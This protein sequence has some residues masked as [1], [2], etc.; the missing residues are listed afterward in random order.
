MLEFPTASGAL[1][2]AEEIAA[3]SDPPVR[4]GVHLGEVSVTE[5][6]DL[7][8]H[9]VNVA[10]RIQQMASPGAVLASGDVKRAIRG[11][12]GE[13]L[14]SQ[15]SVR[16][17]KMSETLPVFA[18]APAEGGRA[19][20]RRLDL[21]SPAIAAVAAL[22]LALAGLGLWLARGV[23]SGSAPRSTRVAILPFQSLGGG[24]QF[25]DFAA[26]LR[27]QIVGVMSANDVP[28]VSQA[29]SEALRGQG[30]GEIVAR[31][32][33]T[34]LLDG[35]V[36]S[37]GRTIGVRVD[38]EDPRQHAT[39]WTASV[40]APASQ[41][42]DLQ[43]RIAAK[44][45]NVLMCAND[46][47]RA[48]SAPTDSD[49]VALFFHAC[50]LSENMEGD[51]QRR[52]QVLDALRQVTSRAPGFARGHSKLASVLADRYRFMPSDQG[53]DRFREASAEARRAL[54]IDPNDADAYQALSLL[55]PVTAFTERERLL[56]RGLSGAPS[57]AGLSFRY[58]QFLAEVGRL[59]EAESFA[60]RAAAHEPLDVQYA[61]YVPYY[62]A[63]GGGSE[64]AEEG[65]VQVSRTW[66]DS[67][68]GWGASLSVAIWAGQT[69]RALAILARAPSYAP[70]EVIEH[71]R[72]CV[73]AMKTLAPSAVA[74]ARRREEARSAGSQADLRDAIQCLAPLELVDASFAMSERYQPTLYVLEGSA[75][76][77]FPST[78][79]M[80]RDRR[81][82][83]LAARIGLVDYWR[84]T[85]KWPDFCS[86]PGLPY[87]CKT[88]AAKVASKRAG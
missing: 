74:A 7:L 65:I 26:G 52:E 82:M 21:R 53:A 61:A 22:V 71:S 63:A 6:G 12:L 34:L 73:L 31:L 85:G 58:A 87:D 13:R 28:T 55:Q 32:G 36:R 86:Q 24:A 79:P 83:K 42:S 51:L 4:T 49:T 38:L 54:A 15:G 80:R 75:I 30:R 40:E 59:G 64:G 44:I 25:N 60:Q 69:D 43:H 84:S 68:I 20:G 14:R 27:D 78:A 45:T 16:L 62:E 46:L 33:V 50:D 37:D 67:P 77:F 41:G 23:W 18:L 76:F 1:A 11:P 9:G 17:D 10:A 70:A 72:G 3:A 56:L 8:G 48:P 39:L 5:S 47:Q 81:F 57:D 88:E 66:P 29:D 2:A 19:K 35:S